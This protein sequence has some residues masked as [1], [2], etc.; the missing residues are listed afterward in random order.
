[1]TIRTFPHFESSSR[2]NFEVVNFTAEQTS[3]RNSRQNSDTIDGHLVRKLK[4]ASVNK[5]I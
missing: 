4:I 1:M 3:F 5:A 2:I